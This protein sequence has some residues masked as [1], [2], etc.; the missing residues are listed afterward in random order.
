MLWDLEPD[1]YNTR[2]EG[3]TQY[4]L[5]RVRPGSIILLHVEIPGRRESRAALREIILGLRSRGFRFVTLT[6]L[7]RQPST[8]SDEV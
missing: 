6:E 7:M 5:E 3:M 2:A 1:T 8:L 4:V